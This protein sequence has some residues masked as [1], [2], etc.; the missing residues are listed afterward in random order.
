[1]TWTTWKSLGVLVLALVALH[2]TIECISA[3]QSAAAS[4]DG[5]AQLAG[6]NVDQQLPGASAA[7]PQ[8]GSSHADESS[9]CDEEEESGGQ[10]SPS[11]CRHKK[12]K[13]REVI[14]LVVIIIPVIIVCG[15]LGELAY[16]YFGSGSSYNRLNG[17]EVQ[18][19]EQEQILEDIKQNQIN[20]REAMQRLIDIEKLQELRT[21]TNSAAIR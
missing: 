8:D 12:H 19:R 5:P 3:E 2:S 16:S 18:I 9:A 17:I 6:P 1:M 21:C 7:T 20:S 15:W 13:K 14:N 10:E 11:K 4:G